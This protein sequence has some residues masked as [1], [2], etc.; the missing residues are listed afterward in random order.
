[1]SALQNESSTNFSQ[2]SL[3]AQKIRKMYKDEAVA[4]GA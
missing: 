4:W 3:L 2:L 1:M